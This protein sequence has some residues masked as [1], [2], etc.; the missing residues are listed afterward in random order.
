M[1]HP[2]C[3]PCRPEQP[4]RPPT[5]PKPS[6][7]GN[8]LT[9]ASP[10]SAGSPPVQSFDPALAYD[11]HAVTEYPTDNG[12][13]D[14]ALFVA[15]RLLGIV[16]AKKLTLGP[17]NVLTQAERYAGARPTAPSTSATSAS[18]SSTPP[19]ARSSGSTT[20]ATPSNAPASVAGFHT[21]DALPSCFGRDFDADCRCLAATPN[22]TPACAPTSAT[23]TPPSRRPSPPA[24]A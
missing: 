10:P 9:P 14:Y 17:Q 19:T 22:D 23:P 15:G 6:R 20:S 4:C 1:E 2:H 16:E 21:P 5:K 13:A 18:R 3:A 24:S 12:P 7:A 8:A 11:H